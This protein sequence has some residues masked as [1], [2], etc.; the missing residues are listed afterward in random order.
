MKRI[1]H[2]IISILSNL[3]PRSKR[4]FVFS[5]FPDFSDNS[6]AMYKYIE[7]KY[8][9][10]CKCVWI[11]E[12][13]ETLKKFPH[14]KACKKYSLL[15]FYYFARARNVFFTHGLYNFVKLRSNDKIVNLWHGMPLK[16]IGL[17]DLNGG[18][19]DPTRAD[20][21][22]ATS[23]FFREIMSKSFN[24]IDTAHTLLTGQPR[25]DLLFQE[26]T[27]FATRNIDTGKY[28]STGIWL[29]TYRRSIVGDIRHDG[30]YNSNGISFLGIEELTQL[31]NHLR[32]GGDLLIIKLHPMDALQKVDFG[33]FTNIIVIKQHEFTEQL[34]PLL[35]AC[36]YLLTDYSSVWID[37]SILKRPIGFVMNDIDEYKKSRGLT[38]ENIEE[39]L[40]GTIID[41]CDKLTAFISSPPPFN[42][43]NLALYNTYCDN[44]SSQRLAE[45]LGICPVIHIDDKTTIKKNNITI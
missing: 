27:F 33:S 9:K 6:Y 14:V 23:P 5:S 2:A 11:F 40:P 26:T 29:P 17:M 10:K 16:V 8:G 32:I 4:I 34:Y 25:N 41:N 42:A 35:G 21:L 1:L 20:Y 45:V 31:D 30:I 28:R 43:T 44:G 24:G 39:K 37:Y 18:G 38:I 36:D 19:T 7:G 3:I 15:S 12:N 13:P 22:I